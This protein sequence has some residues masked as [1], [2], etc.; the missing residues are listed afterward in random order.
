MGVQW[1]IVIFSTRNMVLGVVMFIVGWIGG[2]FG[3]ILWL[4]L[5]NI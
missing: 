5:A 3:F 2:Q 4:R 1:G